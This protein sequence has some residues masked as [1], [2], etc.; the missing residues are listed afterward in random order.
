MINPV[1]DPNALFTGAI[2]SMG[3][4]LWMVFLVLAGTLLIVVCLL[5][6]SAVLGRS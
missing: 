4:Q 5:G 3:S 1:V 6:V 2:A